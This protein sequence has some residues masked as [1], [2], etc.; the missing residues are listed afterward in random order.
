MRLQ[1]NFD[2]DGYII[3]QENL[4]DSL[5]ISNAVLAMDDVINCK[6]QTGVPPKS[7]NWNPGDDTKKI[8]KI[9]QPHLCDDKIY[10][11]FCF[12]PLGEFIA[13]AIG[14]PLFIQL[15]AAQLLYKPEQGES[16]GNVG[17]HQDKQYWP[18]WDGEVFTVWIALSDV[19][20]ESGPVVYARGSH[21]WGGVIEGGDFFDHDNDKIKE[22]ILDKNDQLWAEEPATLPKGGIAIHH[23]FMIHGSYENTSLYPRRSFAIHL[24][25]ENSKPN[26]IK[27]EYTNIE[28][29]GNQRIC[30]IIF[31]K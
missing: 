12:P 9:D 5:L 16:N 17:W 14:G 25:T 26:K 1:D 19:C 18:Y 4:F 7:R 2:K 28:S 15:W 3:H 22:I 13:K 29:V 11:L 21:K 23:K 27:S 30:P 8:R 10:N 24:R 20:I 31:R 6:Y